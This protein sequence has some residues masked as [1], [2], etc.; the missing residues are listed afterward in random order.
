MELPMN[1]AHPRHLRHRDVQTVTNDGSIKVTPM[2]QQIRRAHKQGSALAVATIYGN[3]KAIVTA[4]TTK[5]ACSPAALST[6]VIKI[7]D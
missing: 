1:V 7:G 4:Q 2:G 5:N 3:P 6:C